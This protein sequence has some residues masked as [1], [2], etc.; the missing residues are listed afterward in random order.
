[1]KNIVVIASDANRD[2]A[3]FIPIAAALWQRVVGYTPRVILVRQPH[4]EPALG[5]VVPELANLCGTMGPVDTTS[6]VAPEGYRS[7]TAAQ[8]VR[9]YSA[10]VSPTLA[11]EDYV[12]T[13][14]VDML[15]LSLGAFWHRGKEVQLHHASAYGGEKWPMCYVGTTAATWHAINGTCSDTKLTDA[16]ASV[17]AE[18][19]TGA[20]HD[21][22]WNA[23]EAILAARLR[24]WA[25]P[26][27]VGARADMLNRPGG[28]PVPDRIDR[29]VWPEHPE[30]AGKTD[31]HCP[32]PGW[33]AENWPRI[34]PIL[35]QLVP[36]LVP[37][38]DDYRARFAQM[39]E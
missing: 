28:W 38:A 12:L 3:F 5:V 35:E 32:R 4:A 34:R 23:D 1:M 7:S 11:P 2:Y 27:G 22:A 26:L 36:D 16:L 17:L 25:G 31:A 37:W 21:T 29:V 24:A 10:L 13:S 19:G 6:V 30:V 18:I 9:L 15:P 33:S 39:M 14:D 20:T 8:V